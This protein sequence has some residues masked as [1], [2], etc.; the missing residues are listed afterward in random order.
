[1][2]KKLLFGL[3]SLAALAA[4]TNDDFESQGVVA[5]QTSPIEFEVINNNATMRASMNGNSIVWSAN[6]GD[7]FT[8]YHGGTCGLSEC[9]LQG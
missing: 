1:M 5:E 6:D 9:D 2:N 7:L 3:M 8:L 4:C